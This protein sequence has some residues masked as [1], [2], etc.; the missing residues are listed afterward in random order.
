MRPVSKYAEQAFAGSGP[1]ALARPPRN[2]LGTEWELVWM[3]GD[4]ELDLGGRLLEW[5]SSGEEGVVQLRSAAG[6]CKKVGSG[7]SAVRA[8]APPVYPAGYLRR[9]DHVDGPTVRGCDDSTVRSAFVIS[10][11]NRLISVG[12]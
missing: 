11:L 1:C 5:W 3:S 12:K 6:S 2:L 8:L 9:V 10:D 4:S 7:R